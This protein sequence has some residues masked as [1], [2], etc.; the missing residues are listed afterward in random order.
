M[1]IGTKA[2]AEYRTEQKEEY[3]ALTGL[4]K[5]EKLV[6]NYSA[7]NVYNAFELGWIYVAKGWTGDAFLIGTQ[8][9]A[10]WTEGF[11]AA[12]AFYSQN[13]TI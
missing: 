8:S 5:H 2:I 9:R 13:T 10:D 7:A 6:S 4:E 11:A 1:I 3:D 12:E